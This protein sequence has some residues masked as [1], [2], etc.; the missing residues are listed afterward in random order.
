M[1]GDMERVPHRSGSGAMADLFRTLDWKDL[2][3]E[4]VNFIS[5]FEEE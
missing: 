5:G 1:R 4:T 3:E 2:N